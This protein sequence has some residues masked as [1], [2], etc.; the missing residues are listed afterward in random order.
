MAYK[1]TN[2]NFLTNPFSEIFK[3]LLPKDSDIEEKAI[4][5]NAVTKNTNDY[6]IDGYNY[7][8][9]LD[10]SYQASNFYHS[11]DYITFNEIITDKKSK[12]KKYREMSFFPEISDS[13]D[14]ICDDAI[15]QNKDGEIVSLNIEEEKF[16]HKDIKKIKEISEK[17]ISQIVKFNKNGWELFRKFM[18]DSEL[19]LEKVLDKDK[20]HII[21]LKVIPAF[22]IIPIYEN[23]IITKYL[24]SPTGTFD[25]K[26]N[27][28]MEKNQVIYVHYKQYG[29]DLT[30]VR[31]YLESA[32][33]PY[34]QL[35]N[36]EDCL[37][38]YRLA[39]ATERRVFNVEVGQM[40]TG[41]VQQ[42]LERQ[43]QAWKKN[44]TYDPATGYVNT[45]ANV[46]SLTEDFWFSSRDGKGSSV[47]TLQSGMNLGEIKD[48]EYTLK[49]LYKTLKLPKSRWDDTAQG[50]IIGA[51]S[52]ETTREEIKFAN[53]VKRNQ[54]N[55]KEILIDVL[56]TEL[57]AEGVDEE[58]LD[59]DFFNY[60][61]VQS[62]LFADE[63]DAALL[64]TKFNLLTMASPYIYSPNN[65]IGMISR[66]YALR[67]IFKMS[68]EEY[69]RNMELIEKEKL[70]SEQEQMNDD[71]N[72]EFDQNDDVG[73][74]F[75]QEDNQNGNPEQGNDINNNVD[76]FQG[77]I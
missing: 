25:S 73:A 54:D 65:P 28:Y 43:K 13:L 52:Q 10:N 62:N 9:Q 60:E 20:K 15:V 46:N 55:F 42:F 40:P 44:V 17:V 74:L 27:S 50:T 59:P 75:G 32:I 66:E 14:N 41:K 45:N 3:K 23:G 77:E 71:N 29:K 38:V 19:F 6:D 34:N 35:R 63:K 49:K 16:K 56:I 1:K 5:Q 53:Y 57:K 36:M 61:F 31:G 48:V 18:V 8:T 12:I 72:Q 21:A 39:R 68:D 4:K 33:R 24:Y 26:T 37:V 67:Y 22:N 58:Y 76:N 70:A 69:D 11:I 30:D 2:T 64:E 51:K 7:K 47:T